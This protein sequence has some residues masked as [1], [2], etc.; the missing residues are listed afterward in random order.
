MHIHTDI[1]NYIYMYIYLAFRRPFFQPEA[2]Q[3]EILARM[4]FFRLGCFFLPDCV[5]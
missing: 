4:D 2:V 5:F 3:A 1:Y